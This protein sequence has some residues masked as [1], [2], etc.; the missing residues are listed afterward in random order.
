MDAR[1]EAPRHGNGCPEPGRRLALGVQQLHGC[2]VPGRNHEEVGDRPRGV[3]G[4]LLLVDG[5]SR[6]IVKSGT[7]AVRAYAE[8]AGRG[9]RRR[10]EG[11]ISKGKG[12][13]QA[14]AVGTGDFTIGPAVSML[15]F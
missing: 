4:P 3:F 1:Q 6:G 7:H 12:D 13:G 9:E 11:H 5:L 2:R 15:R 14:V 10:R 8:P